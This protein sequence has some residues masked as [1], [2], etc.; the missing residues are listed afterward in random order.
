MQHIYWAY[1]LRVQ[2]DFLLPELPEVNHEDKSDIIIKR[3][4]IPITLENPT[5]KGVRFEVSKDNFLFRVDNIAGFHVK[6][7]NEIII[8][9]YEGFKEEDMRVFLLSS[10]FAALLNQ[11]ENIVLHGACIEVDGKG[12]IFTGASGSGKSTL[13][14]AFRKKGY[15]ILTDEICAIR[16]SEE[17][18]PIVIP[19]FPKLKLWEDAA[20]NLGEDTKTLLKVRQNLKKYMID[21]EGQFSRNPIPVSKIYLLQLV[22]N[23]EMSIM[24]KKDFEKMN[25]IT[26]NAYC[27]RFRKAHGEKV[28]YLRQCVSLVENTK[29]YSVSYNNKE[30]NLDKLVLTIEQECEN[31]WKE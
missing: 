30:F 23:T 16:I 7:G 29:I 25:I 21:L 6:N 15:K 4:I 18:I 5:E 14:A 8:Q 13:A 3:G 11:R 27:F 20:K 1:G 22:N 28:F 17:G 2:S 19:S 9:P 31:L 24:E 12:I 10:V 26:D